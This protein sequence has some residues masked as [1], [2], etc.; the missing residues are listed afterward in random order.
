MHVA[1]EP[2]RPY[3]GRDCQAVLDAVYEMNAQSANLVEGVL[4]RGEQVP[5]HPL[6]GVYTVLSSA[7]RVDLRM[8]EGT[9]L[10]AEVYRR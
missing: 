1:Y 6:P 8:C 2:A 7:Y 5:G 3:V 9:T 4:L 10:W